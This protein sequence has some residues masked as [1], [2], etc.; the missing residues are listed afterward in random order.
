MYLCTK[1]TKHN[2]KQNLCHFH[3]ILIGGKVFQY[4]SRHVGVVDH[5]QDDDVEAVQEEVVDHLEVGGLGDHLTDTGLDVG[6]HQHA[7]D[8]HHDAVLKDG[9]T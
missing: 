7:S 2:Q 4:M 1:E 6:H 9:D 8:G 5:D 3:V